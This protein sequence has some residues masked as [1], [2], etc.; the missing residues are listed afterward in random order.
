[1]SLILS[2]DIGYASIGWCVLS[3]KDRAPAL[4]DILGPGVVTFPTDDCLASQRRALR[5]ILRKPII[6]KIT[7]LSFFRENEKSSHSKKWL[8]FK[9]RLWLLVSTHG[10]EV[11][12]LRY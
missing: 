9:E 3:A 12:S 11:N 4:P 10:A 2:F 8:L 5:H 6:C 7:A 1:M